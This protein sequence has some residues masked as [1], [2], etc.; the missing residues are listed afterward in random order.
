MFD[1]E[2]LYN[3][4]V[5][6]LFTLQFDEIKK[7]YSDDNFSWKKFQPIFLNLYNLLFKSIESKDIINNYYLFTFLYLNYTNYLKYISSPDFNNQDIYKMIDKIK[8]NKI[9]LNNIMNNIHDDNI[10]KIL[11]INNNFISKK[12]RKKINNLEQRKNIIEEYTNNSKQID[13]FYDMTN[14]NSKKIFNIV[15]FRYLI[16]IKNGYTSYDD[17][18]RKKIINYNNLKILLDFEEFMKKIPFSK[19]ILDLKVKNSDFSV[20]INLNDLINFIVKK[21]SK[22]NI[23]SFNDKYILSNNKYGGKI[24]INFSN[25]ESNNNEFYIYQL[26]YSMI[27]Y[28]IKELSEFNFLKK[29]DNLV[30]INLTSHN[31]TDYTTLLQITHFITISLKI[32]ETHPTDLYECVNPLDY[33]NYYFLS[34]CMFL[35]FVKSDIKTSVGLN[36]FIVDLIKYFYIYAYYDYYFYYSDKLVTTIMKNYNY[37]YEIFNEFIDNLKK[38]LK[39]PKE[40]YSHPPFFDIDDDINSIIYY[41]FEIPSYYKLFD[42][43]NAICYV[44]DKKYYSTNTFDFLIMIK[45]HFIIIP[46]SNNIPQNNLKNKK[47]TNNINSSTSSQNDSDIKSINNNQNKKIST[48]DKTSDYDDLKSKLDSDIITNLSKKDKK[49]MHNNNTYIELNVENSINYLL[50]TDTK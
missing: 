25:S 21:T 24:I 16:S 35:E 7:K 30:K 48:V 12:I 33:T 4:Y 41:S 20:N 13:K 5:Q 50:F 11:K 42:L 27:H 17:F 23:E 2:L 3:E 10:L 34:F 38:T 14:S 39:I 29:T 19:S 44:F 1:T 6:V 28:Q 26:N 46:E 40:L 18:V 47:T 9:I 8:Y 15:L 36:K 31:I 37:K 22:V 45:K 43:I 32:L 49:L